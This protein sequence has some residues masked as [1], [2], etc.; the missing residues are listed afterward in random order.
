MLP[1]T[2]GGRVVNA[3]ARPIYAA[4]RLLERI[5]GLNVFATSLELV[6]TLD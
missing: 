3:A 5:P 4:N 1:L 2:V 6:A